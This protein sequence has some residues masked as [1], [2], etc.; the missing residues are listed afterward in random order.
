MCAEYGLQ[1]RT[2]PEETWLFCLIL[3]HSYLVRDRAMSLD[4]IRSL[5][6]TETLKVAEGHR[7]G[8]DMLAQAKINAERLVMQKGS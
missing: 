3:G 2:I 6:F 1:E 8:F 4:K 5:G 7:R